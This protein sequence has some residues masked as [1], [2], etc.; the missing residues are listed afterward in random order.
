MGEKD[1][2]KTQEPKK[3]YFMDDESKNMDRKPLIESDSYKAAGKLEGKVTLVTGGDSGI[4]AA[5]AILFAKEGAKVA[6][7]YHSSD[8]DAT[9]TENRLKEIGAEVLVF[10]GDVGDESFAEEVISSLTDKWGN[11]DVLVNHAGEQRYQSSITDIKA[12]QIDRTYRTNIFSMFYFVKA[13]LNHLSEGASIINTSSITAYKGN[14]TLMDYSG[15]NG[16]RVAFTRS[17]AQNQEILDKKIR[18]NSVAPGPIWTPL[19]PSTFPEEALEEFGKDGALGRPGEA[20]EL[21]PA[22][23]YLASDDSSYV[24][25][26]T[27][28]VNGGV[29]VNG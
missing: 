11:I 18:V 17:L 3:D 29:I 23:V 20:Y 13:A 1:K 9:R 15:T 25:G 24:T 5:T 19:I 21:A 16:A 26:Q 22:Y 7:T 10:K 6:F 28:H 2:V 27:I 14:P 8:E 12:E 4:G